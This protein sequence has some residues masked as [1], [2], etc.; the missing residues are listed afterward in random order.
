M[1]CNLVF[2]HLQDLFSGEQTADKLHTYRIELINYKRVIDI[3]LDYSKILQVNTTECL[4]LYQGVIL[5]VY[6]DVS[7][8]SLENTTI[9]MIDTSIEQTRPHKQRTQLLSLFNNFFS[10]L[11]QADV[12]AS[13]TMISETVNA[14]N[15]IN[16]D[17]LDTTTA[18][19][20]GEN[21]GDDNT[22]NADVEAN[23]GENTEP[24][25]NLDS[26]L[27]DLELEL[28]LD[29]DSDSEDT[30]SLSLSNSEPGEQTPVPAVIPT[31]SVSAL[32]NTP[33]TTQTLQE[34]L[35][36]LVSMGFTNYQDNMEALIVCSGN[37]DMAVNYLITTS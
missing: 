2:R 20:L 24:Q 7:S 3:I 31:S 28:D 36:T 4:I 1:T 11:A 22:G 16:E 15:E 13:D 34:A 9:Y 26:G 37:V 18:L 29:E 33:P 32:N 14:I 30:L 5:D 19:A 8:L 35:Q 25:R 21:S 23:A 10:Q 6:S 12:L 27:E 17:I